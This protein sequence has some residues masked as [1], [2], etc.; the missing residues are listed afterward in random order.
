MDFGLTEQQRMIREAVA[1]L[2]AVFPAEYW[3][4]LDEERAYPEEFVRALTRAGWLAVLIPQ[5]HGGGGLGITEASIVLEEVN[6]SGGSSAACHAQMYIMGS[7]LRHGS[8]EQKRRFLPQVASGELRFQAFAIT[9]PNSGSDTTRIQTT[10]VRRGDV[11]V[12]N[13]QKIFISRVQH[14]DLMLVVAR[15][16]PRDPARKT[17]SFLSFWLTSERRLERWRCAPS[18]PWSTTRPTRS[19][20]QI[21]GFL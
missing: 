9:E 17:A 7:L 1:Q 14:S 6:R 16:S 12:L 5:E 4:K 2:C 11:Y 8:E 21:S 3:R 19:F 20:S 10:A 15:T 18:A 13:G